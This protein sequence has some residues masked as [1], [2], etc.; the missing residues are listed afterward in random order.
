[1]DRKINCLDQV[2]YVRRYT[3][4]D[5]AAAGIKVVE[6]YN[7]VLRFLLNES[8]ALDIMQLFHNGTNISYL[9]K[10]A[11]TKRETDFMKRFEGGML[12]TCGIDVIGG[13]AG[14]ENHGSFHNIP[15]LITKCECTEEMITVEA[16]IRDTE[17]FGKNLVIK[18]RYETEVGSDTATLSDTLINEGWRDENYSILYHV[19]VGYPML[20]EGVK[21]I[22]ETKKITPRNDWAEKNIGKAFEIEQ[23][24]DN[25]EE[26]CYLLDMKQPSISVVNEK[27]GKKFTLEYSGEQL[28][29]FVEW[30]SMASGDYALGLE[31]STSLLDDNF[32]FSKIE[33]QDEIYF[34]LT[35]KVE[36]L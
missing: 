30:K 20:D 31:P 29:H 8:K 24:E 35:L 36:N 22:A 19:N 34:N 25:K 27:L 33:A 23:P 32:A 1:M 4:T 28:P 5:G 17:L 26:T 21:I 9:C 6:V 12:Y 16:T 15:A 2:A 10:N 13:Q 11:F 3:L 18:R 7:G 14:Y